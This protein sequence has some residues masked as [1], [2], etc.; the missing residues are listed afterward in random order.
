MKSNPHYVTKAERELL[1]HALHVA[2]GADRAY[3][4]IAQKI[5]RPDRDRATECNVERR[6][7]LTCRLRM[8]IERADMIDVY[9][10]P[11]S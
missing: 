8:V 7:I 9:P 3:L 5:G 1:V 6:L 2:A 4:S 10:L 11:K